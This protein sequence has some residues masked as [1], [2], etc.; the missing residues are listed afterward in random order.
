MVAT[1]QTEEPMTFPDLGKDHEKTVITGSIGP[2]SC[3]WDV[4]THKQNIGLL[5]G[6]PTPIQESVTYAEAITAVFSEFD[7]CHDR[8]DEGEKDFIPIGA[9]SWQEMQAIAIR[10]STGC[11]P[12]PNSIVSGG[13]N[14]RQEVGIQFLEESD[15]LFERWFGG[16]YPYP[17]TWNP[18]TYSV[19]FA[20]CEQCDDGPKER[21]LSNGEICAEQ[22]K[23]YEKFARK[24]CN[25]F[26]QI[27][28]FEQETRASI[29]GNSTVKRTHSH[30][31][32]LKNNVAIQTSPDQTFTN[33][34]FSS[35]QVLSLSASFNKI[36]K[37]VEVQGG[38]DSWNET[39]YQKFASDGKIRITLENEY[40]Y[41][42]CVC[43]L[44][45]GPPNI[46][47]SF[48]SIRPW[49]PKKFK[50]WKEFFKEVNKTFP[51][52]SVEDIPVLSIDIQ[53]YYR[54]AEAEI[55]YGIPN[56]TYR[57]VEN[58]DGSYTYRFDV[59]D[60]LEMD[61]VLANL[62]GSIGDILSNTANK[63]Q[64]I[65][66]FGHEIT[67]NTQLG[68][69][70]IKTALETSFDKYEFY[71]TFYND[72][73]AKL[74]LVMVALND[75]LKDAVSNVD[76]N[77]FTKNVNGEVCVIGRNVSYSKTVYKIHQ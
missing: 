6:Q 68:G 59:D 10:G 56:Y 63:E 60:H 38:R 11:V 27:E 57:E 28:S 47:Q 51:A 16:H 19:D 41:P 3:V 26:S 72:A 40:D 48:G 54:T 14:C 2:N 5:T 45:S 37:F 12:Q 71:N 8:S 1:I 43:E 67:S 55:M 42:S 52:A 50:S 33:K 61:S 76:V 49:D 13:R 53:S 17:G 69:G 25:E 39:K 62:T 58:S 46:T 75:S 20:Q 24:T 21:T 4:K 29:Q 65:V 34:G 31:Y 7:C 22:K 74:N 32:V 15:S 36:Y 44:S 73:K 77:E 70:D 23:L 35:N 18:S 64:M 9:I 66:P 30:T